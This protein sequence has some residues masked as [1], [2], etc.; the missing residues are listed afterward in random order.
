MIALARQ[1]E[2]ED[3]WLRAERQ[4][5]GRGRQGR[6]WVSIRGN[7]YASTIVRLKED[8]PPPATLSLVAGSALWSLV[9][10]EMNDPDFRGHVSK[11]VELEPN[12]RWSDKLVLKWPNDLLL[13]G[14][15][16]A[17][18]LLERDRDAVIIGFGVN[19]ADHPRDLDQPANSLAKYVDPP[20]PDVFL[21]YLAGIF[22][23]SLQEWREHGLSYLR[24]S[25]MEKSFPIGQPMAIHDRDNN[26]ISGEFAGLSEDCALRLRLA[27]GSVRVM[28]AGD[29]FLI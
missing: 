25:W 1:G 10:L 6:K 5:G 13:D 4:I 17:G 20:T 23:H 29:V 28:H 12:L 8:D 22:R 11:P 26:R 9:F 2:P 27:D 7:L 16:M 19:L 3:S 24:Y 18:I 21:D 14:A 15:K